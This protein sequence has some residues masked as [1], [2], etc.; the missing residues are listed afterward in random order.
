MQFLQLLRR[1]YRDH[2]EVGFYADQMSISA[3]YMTTLVKKASGKSA[4]QWGEK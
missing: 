4:I 1:H 3:K 2:R